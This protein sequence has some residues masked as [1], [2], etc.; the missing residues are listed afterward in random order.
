LKNG[1]KEENQPE[2]RGPGEKEERGTYRRSR[3]TELNNK[4]KV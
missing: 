4:K 3:R 2:E 1:V